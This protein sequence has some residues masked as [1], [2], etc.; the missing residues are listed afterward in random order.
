MVPRTYLVAAL[1]VTAP[2]AGCSGVLD[3][4]GP[5]GVSERLILF[6]SLTIMLAIVVPVILAIDRLC[7]VVPRLEPAR[8]LL[9]GMGVFRPSRADRLGR[10][11]RSS[12][13]FS[14]ASPGSVRMPLDP[15]M[16]LA[17]KRQA[18][19]GRGRVA[20]LEMAVHLSGRGR[21][22]RQPAR[23]FRSAR[24]CISG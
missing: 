9:A 22:Q 3:P 13:R 24:P 19:R 7:L 5:V 8:L 6:N 12:S 21:R 11:R 17:A 4:R 20:R 2:L 15:F 16:P 14:A 18:R 1:F 23:R 10:S